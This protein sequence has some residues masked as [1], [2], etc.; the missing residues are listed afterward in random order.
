MFVIRQLWYS[1]LADNL[2]VW[3]K[4]DFGGFCEGLDLKLVSWRVGVEFDDF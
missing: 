4:S 2:R 3:K 1:C